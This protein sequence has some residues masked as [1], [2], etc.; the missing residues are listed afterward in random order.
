MQWRPASQS[1]WNLYSQVNILSPS[2]RAPNAKQNVNA[3][4]RIAATVWDI[5]ALMAQ[6]MPQSD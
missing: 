5:P 4:S 2:G 6:S 1:K 3:V